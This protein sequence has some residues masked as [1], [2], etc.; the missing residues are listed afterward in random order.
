MLALLAVA[1]PFIFG[2]PVK[3]FCSGADANFALSLTKGYMGMLQAGVVCPRWLPESNDGLGSPAFL[4]YGRLPFFI[5]GVLGLGLR[6]GPVT[7]LLSG[8]V[9]F[10]LLA[11]CTCRAWLRLH[12]SERAADCGALAFVALPFVMSM[13][14]VTRVGFAETAAT[15]FIPLLFLAVEKA[16]VKRRPWLP[17]AAS[18]CTYALLVFTHLP[19]FV[20]AAAVMMLYIVLRGSQRMAWV[21]VSGLSLGLLLSAASVGPAL[22]LQNTISP[23]AW[24]DDPHLQLT[25]NLLF[26]TALSQQLDFSAAELELYSTWLLC[27]ALLLI[28]WR[29]KDELPQVEQSRGRALAI[30]LGIVLLAMTGLAR[31]FWLA[32]GP[33]SVLQFPWRLFP[34]TVILATALAALWVGDERRRATICVL[35]SAALITGQ[36]AFAAAGAFLSHSAFQAHHHVPG[37]VAG[38]LPV[39][40]PYAQRNLASFARK[41]SLVPEYI[42][43]DARRAGWHLSPEFDQ[44]LPG[45]A[46][47]F[48]PPPPENLAETRLPDGTIR[49]TGSLPHSESVLLPV[50]YFPDEGLVEMPDRPV[51]LDRSTGLA[52]VSLPAGRVA[53]SLTHARLL[54]SIRYGQIGSTVGAGLLMLCLLLAWRGDLVHA[55]LRANQESALPIA[56]PREGNIT[57]ARG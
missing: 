40:A 29:K 33:L 3:G 5:A 34:S 28:G 12:T 43:A 52:K 44:L 11:F 49:V 2:L 6:L 46:A 35:C 31:P 41:R 30:S 13:D 42:P 50:F 20:L 18:A 37:R 53:A 48:I 7:A 10:R 51:V 39:Y 26:T 23:A 36:F 27:A 8:F 19:Q 17:I 55:R 9:F 45:A 1:G 15:A 47:S 16:H 56:A 24:S 57:A 4:F 32:A 54:P 22:V 14:P 38:R 21:N 25:N